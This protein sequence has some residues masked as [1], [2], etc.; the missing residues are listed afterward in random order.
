VADWVPV[1]LVEEVNVIVLFVVA[2]LDPEVEPGVKSR[3]ATTMSD[4]E[5]ETTDPTAMPPARAPAPPEGNPDGGVTPDGKPEGGVPPLPPEGRVPPKPPPPLASQDP[6]AAAV[7]VTETVV[8]VKLVAPDVVPEAATAMTQ[9]PTLMAFAATLTCCVNFVAE[10]HDTA[11]WPFCWLCTCIVAP[12]TAA[13]SPE[14]AGPRPRPGVGAPDSAAPEGDAVTFEVPEP[15]AEEPPHPDRMR[16]APTASAPPRLRTFGWAARGRLR[17][18]WSAEPG[19]VGR[20]IVDLSEL[21]GH[22]TGTRTELWC[23]W[24]L[25]T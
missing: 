3:A 5:I 20:N 1:I 9:S 17:S 10:V 11:T 2:G 21:R 24:L 12:E 15:P 4:P 8:A 7:A 22:C 14:A 18:G 6:V 23:G 25:A 19:R 13:I 16:T